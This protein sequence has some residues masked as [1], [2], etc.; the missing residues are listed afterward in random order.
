MNPIPIARA[1][2][3]DVIVS[4]AFTQGEEASVMSSLNIIPRRI[5]SWGQ[6]RHVS[7]A[8][9]KTQLLVVSWSNCDI[10]PI[11]N[12]TSLE[13]QQKMMILGVTYDNMLTFKTH[14]EQLAR[15]AAGT[16]ICLRRISYLRE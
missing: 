12:E 13:P 10:R 1:F 9:Q 11:F 2:A 15:T 3:D 4:V 7:L 5:E 16:L 14:A 6:R 8:P